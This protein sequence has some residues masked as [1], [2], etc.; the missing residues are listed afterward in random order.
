MDWAGVA[1]IAIL[2]WGGVKA[3]Q[4]KYG[5]VSDENGNEMRIAE[6]EKHD[7]SQTKAEV[8]ELKDRVKVLE[9]LV[10]DRGYSLSEE[11]EAL[12]DAP[13]NGERSSGVPLNVSQKERV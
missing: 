1:I 7:D 11:I 5:I 3:V 4:A 2:V 13:S 12:R 6:Q 10:T 9:R 8:A